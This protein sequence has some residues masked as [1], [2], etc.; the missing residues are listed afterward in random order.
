MGP[1]SHVGGRGDIGRHQKRLSAYILKG[2]QTNHHSCHRRLIDPRSVTSFFMQFFNILSLILS[3]LGI[4]GIFYSLRLL[5]P[6]N[7]VPFVS[8]SLNEAIT[9]LEHAVAINI[10]NVND[11]RASL[12]MYAHVCLYHHCSPT[13][14]T[15]PSE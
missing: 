15:Q 9:L 11:Y 10:P 13:E 1:V 5:L 14:R 2:P 7:I 4:Y 12:A 8:T 3:F 6:R